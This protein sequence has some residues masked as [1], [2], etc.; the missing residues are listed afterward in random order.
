MPCSISD[1]HLSCHSIFNQVHNRYRHLRIKLINQFQLEIQEYC[2]YQAYEGQF[3]I[4]HLKWL[5][6]VEGNHSRIRK[7]SFIRFLFCSEFI[8]KS[9]SGRTIQ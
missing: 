2:S 3:R 9:H 1:I 6:I 8:H 5:C 4:P 7:S